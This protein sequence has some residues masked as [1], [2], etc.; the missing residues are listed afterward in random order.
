M[1][2][3]LVLYSNSIIRITISFLSGLYYVIQCPFIAHRNGFAKK[4]KKI[5][6]LIFFEKYSS[7]L[8]YFGL[9]L[10]TVVIHV[11]LSEHEPGPAFSKNRT[12][13]TN[14]RIRYKFVFNKG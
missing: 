9:I 6:A 4:K 14:D 13:A 3:E 8:R 7:I 2:N 1:F 11:L 5:I 12:Y 10:I